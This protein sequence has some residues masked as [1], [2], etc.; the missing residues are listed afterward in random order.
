MIRSLKQ[1]V[2]LVY[3]LTAQ[4][5]ADKCFCLSK[6]LNVPYVLAEHAP[7]PYPGH[8]I[9]NL[10][11]SCIENAD[12][13]LII[14]K[15]KIRQIMLQ[16][17]KLGNYRYV[18][19]YVN[20]ETFI[21]SPFPHQNKTFVIVAANSFYKNYDMFIRTIDKLSA[22]TDKNFSVLIVGFAANKGYSK[23]T[24]ELVAKVQASKF[25]DKVELIPS[26]ARSEMPK[27]LNR[28]DAF[29]MT[30]IQE[31]QPVS[32]LEAACCGLPIF[33][34]RCGGVEDYVTESI[35]RIVPIDDSD[36]LA[37][38][39]NDFLDEKIVFD[40]KHIREVIVSKFGHDAFV[41]NVST[42]FYSL[43]N[44]AEEE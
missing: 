35:G 29:V 19:N 30:S 16:N 13:H 39:L 38:L 36:L 22:I 18:G 5:M 14:S 27:I 43:I 25:A 9:T 6:A 15:D 12:A 10:Q 21:F 11:K 42:V 4:D 2:D 24:E 26:A 33:S 37:T 8:I 7:F 34:T 20:E 32:A 44:K 40:K 28:C 41:K 3:G 1:T 17:I 31:G 23:N